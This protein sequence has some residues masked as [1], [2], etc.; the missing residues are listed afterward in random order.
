M[1]TQ[2]LA[3]SCCTEKGRASGHWVTC[4]GTT[5]PCQNPSESTGLVGGDVGCYVLKLQAMATSSRCTVSS[6]LPLQ[7]ACSGVCLPLEAITLTRCGTLAPSAPIDGKARSASLG[8]TNRNLAVDSELP[9]RQAGGRRSAARS[10]LLIIDQ[11]EKQGT[12]ACFCWAA[13][14]KPAPSWDHPHHT[15]EKPKAQPASSEQQAGWRGVGIS[16][17]SGTSETVGGG[18][19]FLLALGYNRM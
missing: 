15:K 14:G 7:C 13:D 6:V 19:A 11:Q 9:V 2:P 4:P 12:S 5:R 3:G 1:E 17:Q 18:T 8:L 16:S 10:V